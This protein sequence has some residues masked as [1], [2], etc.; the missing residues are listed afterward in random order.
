MST[1]SICVCE[2][3][4]GS[5]TQAEVGFDI[6]TGLITSWSDTSDGSTNYPWD[7]WGE[8]NPV[9]K[10]IIQFIVDMD[11]WFNDFETDFRKPFIGGEF[12]VFRDYIESLIDNTIV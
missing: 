8:Y 10:S 12:N 6:S 9:G 2:T 1:L 5:S 11:K 4:F 3:S 7:G